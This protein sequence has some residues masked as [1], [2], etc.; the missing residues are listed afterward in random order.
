MEKRTVLAIVLSTLVF[1]VFQV[2][3]SV[4]YPATEV[5]IDVP[6]EIVIE[7]NNEIIY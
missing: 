5:E 1:F 3:N 7:E 6:E 4:L 2:L